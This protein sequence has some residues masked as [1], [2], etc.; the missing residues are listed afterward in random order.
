M[1]HEDYLDW[2]P[3]RWMLMLFSLVISRW[4]HCVRESSNKCF[5]NIVESWETQPLENLGFNHQQNFSGTGFDFYL[6]LLGH[7]FPTNPS[8]LSWKQIMVLCLRASHHWAIQILVKNVGL[9]KSN[10]IGW[11]ENNWFCRWSHAHKATLQHKIHISA[12]V[13]MASS[14]ITSDMWQLWSPDWVQLLWS[15]KEE[16]SNNIIARGLWQAQRANYTVERKK[17]K[18]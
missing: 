16:Q 6:P 14:K 8:S 5:L 18:D 15:H 2:I 7:V 3:S 11:Q 13:S 10:K 9:A 4:C 17:I 12:A 1:G